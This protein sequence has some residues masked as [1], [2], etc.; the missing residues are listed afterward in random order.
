MSNKYKGFTNKATW[1]SDNLNAAFKA[2]ENGSSVRETARLFR[3]SVGCKPVFSIEEERDLTAQIIKLSKLLYRFNNENGRNGQRVFL[4]RN[5]QISFKKPEATSLNRTKAFN[6]QKV[7][8]FYENLNKLL[9]RYQ[10]KQFR[11]FN[12]DETGIT[13]VQRQARMYAEK[14]ERRTVKYGTVS[15]EDGE[16]NSTDSDS[17]KKIDEDICMVCGEFDK[18]N[19]LWLRYL[20]CS[21]WADAANAKTEKGQK[22]ICDFCE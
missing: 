9:E 14:G 1:T 7:A 5:P 22:F 8:L 4:R 6:Q 3:P 17:K 20:M 13:T 19:E 16:E 12:T 21:D 10:F 15:S 2:I 11:I 18:T